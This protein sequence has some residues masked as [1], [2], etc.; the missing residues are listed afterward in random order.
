MSIDYLINTVVY[1]LDSDNTLQW[2]PLM[3]WKKYLF[4]QPSQS[5]SYS[6]HSDCIRC[7]YTLLQKLSNQPFKFEL[8]KKQQCS[9]S[10]Y[11]P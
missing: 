10:N 4:S 1:S 8:Q 11:L 5:H 3:Q 7:S 2:K 6:P 9:N